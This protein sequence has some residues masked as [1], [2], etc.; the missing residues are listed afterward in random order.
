MKNTGKLMK[1]AGYVCDAVDMGASVVNIFRG[2]ESIGHGAKKFVKKGVSFAVRKGVGRIVA[3]SIL[4]TG[5]APA[6]IGFV[7]VSAVELAIDKV[8]KN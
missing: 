7:A 8:W 1:N 5:L 4:G 3:G 2:K 6:V